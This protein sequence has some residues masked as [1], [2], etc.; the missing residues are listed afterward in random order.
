MGG[1]GTWD[2]AIAYPDRF[3]AIA[4]ICGGGNP[5]RASAI[6]ERAD[7]GLPR[8]QGRAVPVAASVEMVDALSRSAAT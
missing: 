5:Y 4:P 3:A 8:R 2:T 7:L 1:F 6:E